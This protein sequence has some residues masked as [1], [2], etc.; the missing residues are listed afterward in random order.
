MNK[1]SF[2]E[3]YYKGSFSEDF[4]GFKL[5]FKLQ[6]GCQNLISLPPLARKRKSTAKIEIVMK[7]EDQWI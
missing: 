4:Q 2:P 1:I 6:I 3:A 7:V 5:S